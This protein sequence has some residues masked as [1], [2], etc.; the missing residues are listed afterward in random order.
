VKHF[1]T[2][3]L[4]TYKGKGL[5]PFEELRGGDAPGVFP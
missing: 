3:I 5:A 1:L 4:E 2:D